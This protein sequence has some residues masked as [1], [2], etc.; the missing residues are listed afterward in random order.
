MRKLNYILSRLRYVLRHGLQRGGTFGHCPICE[1]RTIFYKEGDWLRDQYKCI[2]CFSIPRFRALVSVLDKF[3]PNW[4]ELE[5]HESSPG[6][7]ASEKL[8]RE[9]KQCVQ[10]HFFP[11]FPLGETCDGY[12]CEDLER[13]TF[14]D[15]TF[16]LVISQDVFEHV[17]DPAKGFAEVAR[18]LK[19][20]GAHVFTVPWP[21]WQQTLVRAARDNNG[22]ICYYAEPDYHGNPI[23]PKGSL[24]V[25]EWGAD[26]CDFIFRWS[27]LTTTVVHICD[28][29]QG[30]E[31]E[32]IEVFISRKAN[33]E[34]P[35]QGKKNK[36]QAVQL[37][38]Q[39]TDV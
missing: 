26:F 4:R 25:T 19:A 10:T 35:H 29:N 27:G 30:I 39:P 37:E 24:V 16:D 20:G 13:Q 7:A 3:F 18:T 9:C 32:F 8:A 21:Y 14:S 23:D 34:V 36:V 17:L 22:G 12:R 33:T 2:R 28:R 31:A 38:Q 15:S 1:R 5:I 6:G 11:A